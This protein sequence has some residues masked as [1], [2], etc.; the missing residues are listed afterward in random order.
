MRKAVL[1]RISL[2]ACAIMTFLAVP[3][4]A[5]TAPLSL[6]QMF[7][8]S[9]SAIANQ[10]NQYTYLLRNMQQTP[11]FFN[12][13]SGSKRLGIIQ[14]VSTCGHHLAPLGACK[15][16]LSFKAPKTEGQF[17]T[18][19]NITTPAKQTFQL[20]LTF[21]VINKPLVSKIT[22]SS[23]ELQWQALPG[24]YGGQAMNMIVSSNNPEHLYTAVYGIGVYR[25]VNAGKSWEIVNNIQ[26]NPPVTQV[27]MSQGVLYALAFEGPG[28][29]IF[30]SVDQGRHWTQTN[31]NLPMLF[32]PHL[33]PANHVLY[34]STANGLYVTKDGGENWNYINIG[35][36]EGV[37]V[38]TIQGQTMYVG[39]DGYLARSING[40]INWTLINNLP[41][42]NF[43]IKA[44]LNIQG[45][46][47]VGGN[48]AGVGEGPIFKSTDDGK[49]WSNAS[50]GINSNFHITG[51]GSQGDAIY[52]YGYSSSG[53][54]YGVFKSIDNGNN[55][56]PVNGLPNANDMTVNNST[57]Y[58]ATNQGIYKSTDAGS[59][60]QA[61]N[62]GIM[63][64][65]VAD[66]FS[67]KN[68]T[69]FAVTENSGMY[70]SIDNGQSWSTVNL[71]KPVTT[72]FQSASIQ[73]DDNSNLYALLDGSVF[74]SDNDGNTWT[75][76]NLPHSEYTHA[77]I[78]PSVMLVSG[79]AIYLGTAFGIY[80]STNGGASWSYQMT[81]WQFFN[82]IVLLRGTNR[83]YLS[84]DINSDI[85]NYFLWMPANNINDVKAIDTTL[86]NITEFVTAKSHPNTLYAL[87]GSLYESKD[88]GNNWNMVNNGISNNT[89]VT[90]LLTDGSNWFAAAFDPTATSGYSAYL[91]T[92]QG[93]SW[94][95]ASNGLEQNTD[96]LSLAEN[97][98]FI[99]AGTT[100]PGIYRA[101]QPAN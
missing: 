51:F 21:N 7:G 87:A 18:H 9:S 95:P 24:P 1:S 67:L 16:A 33:Y 45:T 90:S 80:E 31:N 39:G 98:N 56:T 52:A 15:L 4:F 23:S 5:T 19:L 43:S 3:A 82:S 86:P 6:M 29:N 40:G 83:I 48:G 72:S 42:I 60:W 53:G 97:N 49:N 66:L 94:I 35:N 79:K 81:T 47:Y 2:A 54:S 77:T 75:M 91:S 76:L 61:I 26:G 88:G 25:S 37:N 12:I 14:A 22:D 89:D 69:L 8:S 93:K 71:N 20:P 55:W 84:Y 30:K 41:S 64:N 44:L 50:T 13:T 36:G 34:A 28:D 101:S 96:I 11:V 32:S 27:V 92:N 99:F 10:G 58:A 78:F 57:L 68:G 70:K 46:I 63:G 59:A 17:K 73:E 62:N 85:E 38:A 100:N 65:S 74:K